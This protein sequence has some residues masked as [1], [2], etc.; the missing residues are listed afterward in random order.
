M[1]RRSPLSSLVIPVSSAALL[2]AV[3]AGGCASSGG[4]SGEK[5]AQPLSSVASTQPMKAHE[6]MDPADFRAAMQRAGELE[7]SDRTRADGVYTTTLSR[8]DL[9]TEQR[10][11]AQMRLGRL[12]LA[13]GRLDEARMLGQQALELRPG[14]NDAK[15][16]LEK[17]DAAAATGHGA[18]A[19]GENAPEKKKGERRKEDGAPSPER[20]AKRAEKQAEKK[21]AAGV[22]AT[23][24]APADLAAL[25][26]KNAALGEQMHGLQTER[27]LLQGRVK[28]LEAQ[29]AELK[30]AAD[31]KHAADAPPAK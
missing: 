11:T 10:A 29:L 12:R 3:L 21:A 17:V 27:D 20:A 6:M 1:A 8:A 4:S 22:A 26:K 28:E 9:T 15:A 19:A 30:K 5:S 16:L 23:D 2:A 31:A 14:W 18:T 7:K 25:R 13:Q 24:A